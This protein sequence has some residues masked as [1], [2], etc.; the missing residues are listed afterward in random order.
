MNAESGVDMPPWI[1]RAAISVNLILWLAAFGT[2]FRHDPAANGSVR[3]II[4][5]GLAFAAILQHVEW[6][7]RMGMRSFRLW[8]PKWPR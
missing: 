5:A 8:W 4:G 2:T 6:T 7:H 1:L 3:W